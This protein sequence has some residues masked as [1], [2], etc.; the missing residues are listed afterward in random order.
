MTYE[1]LIRE[2]EETEVTVIE[3]TF[4]S[5]AKGLCKGNKIAI[6][7]NLRTVEKA[8]VLAEELGH[9]HT[10][11][12]DILDQGDIINAKQERKARAWAYKKMV[13][14]EALIAALVSGY[15]QTHEMAEYL[16]VDERFLRECLEYYGWI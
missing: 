15:R 4:E 6:R 7:K 2:A 13:P 12:G 16:D 1:D 9:Y 3:K 11:V 14:F 8:C 5:K 10:T